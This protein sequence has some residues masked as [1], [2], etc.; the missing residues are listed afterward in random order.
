M[1]N[2]P[3]RLVL[4]G[5]GEASPSGRKVFDWLFKR[6]PSPL[7]IALLETPAGFQPNSALVA[8]RIETF[9]KERLSGHTLD[10]TIV[11]ARR[12][13]SA[14][15]TDDPAYADMV[16]RADS[17][18]MGP[19]SPTYAVRHLLGSMLWDAARYR[20]SEGGTLVLASAAVLALGK[21]TLPVYEIY[22]VGADLEW[23]PGLDLFGP[24]GGPPLVFVPHFSNH[25]GGAELDTTHCYMGAARFDQLHAL[26]PKDAVIIG[27]DEHTSLICN[28]ADNTGTVLGQGVITL[29]RGG[30][31]TIFPS[32]A[33][34][35]LREWGTFDWSALAHDVPASLIERAA[36]LEQLQ[37]RG[38]EVPPV[39]MEVLALV[40]QREAARQRR[41]WAS[42]DVLR[43]E[44]ARRGHQVDDTPTGP[45]IT[46]LV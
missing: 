30:E 35:S 43:A 32:G 21:Y 23:T 45:R 10:I 20:F 37:K 8:G 29:I 28:M 24:A 33:T 27:V 46:A 42:A 16:L 14:H 41:D 15:S 39:P 11:P 1:A 9:L 2:Q 12:R 4:M 31:R 7:R 40:E 36:E 5:S 17:T 26:L 44:I 19:G 34:F 3:G 25:E 22:K 6:L 18:F 13:G 38:P